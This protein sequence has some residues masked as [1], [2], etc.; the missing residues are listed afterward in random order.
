MKDML[1]RFLLYTVSYFLQT[2]SILAESADVTVFEL[3]PFSTQ[4]LIAQKG[5]NPNPFEWPL[6]VATLVGTF[7]GSLRWS[8]DLLQVTLR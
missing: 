4:L 3:P 5:V 2:R 7:L 8:L 1:L 6:I